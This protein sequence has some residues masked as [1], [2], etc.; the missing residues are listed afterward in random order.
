MP[1]SETEHSCHDEFGVSDRE[2]ETVAVGKTGWRSGSKRE[3]EV[4]KR[5]C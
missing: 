2:R 4:C 5:E 1:S 3:A